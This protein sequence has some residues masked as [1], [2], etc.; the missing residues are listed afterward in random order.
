MPAPFRNADISVE[1]RESVCHCPEGRT[2]CRRS[3][4]DFDVFVLWR[5]RTWTGAAVSKAV[6]I[7]NSRRAA[8]TVVLA[9]KAQIVEDRNKTN[10]IGRPVGKWREGGIR[11]QNLKTS[12]R[13]AR[14]STNA[15]EY[16]FPLTVFEQVHFVHRDDESSVIVIISQHDVYC[17]KKKKTI[18]IMIIIIIKATYY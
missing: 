15:I 3:R 6:Q 16:I 8:T 17:K 5:S 13:N 18:V 2:R 10:S 12:F 9:A 14:F 1:T 11:N 7:S 4:S